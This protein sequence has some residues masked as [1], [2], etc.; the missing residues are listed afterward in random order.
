MKIVKILK[1]WLPV[2]AVV[3]IVSIALDFYYSRNLPK[4]NA[5]PLS[6][7]TTLGAQV[8]LLSASQVSPVVVY[9]WATWCGP[10]KL[11]SPTINQIADS[12]P[13]ISVAMQSGDEGSVN[14]YL[15]SQ[16]YDY[17]TINDPNGKISRDW[18]VQVTPTVVIVRNGKIEFITSGVSSPIGLWL[19]LWL[20]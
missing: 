7:M 10:C 13:V 16:Q 3:L 1:E 15:Q 19:R 14:Q 6:A 8:D 12:Y 9:F 2:L 20:S 11:V 18:G 4:E 5:L 17:D